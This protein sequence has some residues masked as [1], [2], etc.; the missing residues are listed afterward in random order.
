MEWLETPK[1]NEEG[2]GI[3]NTKRSSIQVYPQK[4][5]DHLLLV[6]LQE[7]QLWWELPKASSP[8]TK[9]SMMINR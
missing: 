6:D 3:E 2:S 8:R 9:E 5:V 4:V 1:D 7:R